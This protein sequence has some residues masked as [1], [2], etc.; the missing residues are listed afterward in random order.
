MCA[1]ASTPT[2]LQSLH[3]S[4]AAIVSALATAV[5]A[6]S[7]LSAAG[8][9]IAD[10]HSLLPSSSSLQSQSVAA[11]ALHSRIDRAV[12]PSSPFLASLRRV[13]SLSAAVTDGD[14]VAGHVD[15]LREA[16][17][18]CVERGEE[19]VRR[20]E[21]AVVF[22]G[23]TTTTKATA[24]RRRRRLEEAAAA[25]R[26]VYE[27]EAETMRFEGPLD[28]A[29]VRLQDLFE[30]ILLRMKHADFTGGEEGEEVGYEVG[31]E[32][33]VEAAARMAR[34][35]AGNDCLDICL[36]IYV[37]A[38]YRRAAKAMMRLNPEYLKSYTP[39]AIDAMDWESLESA[40]SR[41]GPHFHVAISGVLAA[42][43]R[44]CSR[45]L[46]ALPPAVWPECFAKIAARI[47]S[48][49]FRFADGVSSSSGAAAREPQ[50]LFKLLDMHAAVASEGDR[51]DDLF[52]S[53]SGDGD[54]ENDQSA[55]LL[56]IR[57]RA[58]EVELALS[59][60]AAAAFFE[61]TLRVETHHAAVSVSVSGDGH[62]SKIVRYAVNY[63]KCL[64]SDDYRR[65]IESALSAGGGDFAEAAGSVMEAL[66]RHVEEARR[67]CGD[68]V[69]GHVAAM[70][71]YWYIY[72][73]SRG[74]HLA[75]LVGEEA[76]RRRFKAAAEEAAWEYHQAVWDPLVRIVDFT[77][78]D[79]DPEEAREKAAAFAEAM[80]ERV[81]R[82]RRYRI[83]DGD[84]REQIK[85]AAARAV[86]GA[87]AAFVKAN[88]ETVAGRREFLPVDAVEGMVRKVFDEM[89]GGGS[90]GRRRSRR[91]SGSLEGFE[92]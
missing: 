76:M 79:V 83:P 57:E 64:A 9:R 48:A 80:E 88:G 32:E 51:L 36:D 31:R 73:R 1:H 25:L 53:S 22:I 38:R 12:A 41:W 82:R 55:T 87:Y 60:A 21:E 13:S 11:V 49:F 77:T 35:L 71:S 91:Q 70:N 47:V 5:E 17:E 34:T 44:L 63:L 46:A 39:E 19:A 50:R 3:A 89:G 52:S 28:D 42:E 2:I 74:S 43:R 81:G 16:V 85:A 14:D 66:R 10:L 6:E 61:F 92:D 23:R 84:L 75:R 86:R 8:D 20:V 29:L 65:L 72:M 33:E 7:A 27:A 37:K 45:V 67:S 54:G 59:R 62:V 4:R 40:M 18:E 90:D 26:A 30:G 15:R 78:G 69:A 68:D 58:T 24:G 56:A